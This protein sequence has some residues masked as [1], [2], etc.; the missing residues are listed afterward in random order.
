M[1]ILGDSVCVVMFIGVVGEKVYFIGELYDQLFFVLMQLIENLINIEQVFLVEVD[2][3]VCCGLFDFFVDLVVNCFDFLIVCEKGFKLLCVN[4]DIIVDCGE[5]WEWCVGVL[6]VFYI[7]MGG[8]S[9]YFGKLYLFIY[10]FVCCCMVVFGYDV[11]IVCF[12]V[13]GDGIC[14]DVLG[15]IGEGIDLLFIMGGLVVE[16]IGIIDQFDEIKL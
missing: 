11:E 4:F 6:V 16:E 7:E 10:D 15:V 2:G 9:F 12:I 5:E 14:I 3:I 13:I 1:V 8:E